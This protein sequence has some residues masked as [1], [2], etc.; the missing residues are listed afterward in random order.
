MYLPAEGILERLPP[1]LFFDSS[2]QPR[3]IVTVKMSASSTIIKF[4]YVN[5]QE[6]VTD[7]KKKHKADCKFCK[8]TISETSGT[9][10]NFN[11]HLQRH[12]PAR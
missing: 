9:T 11:R 3:E 12:H 5:H 2:I 10:S 8:K 4:G 1:S 7:G 6:F